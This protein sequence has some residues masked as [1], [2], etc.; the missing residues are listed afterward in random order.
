M[1][2]PAETVGRVAAHL[3]LDFTAARA[4]ESELRYYAKS[5]DPGEPFDPAGR[6]ARPALPEGDA[7]RVLEVVGD[8]PERL[9]ARRPSAGQ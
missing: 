3:G 7:A 5:T 8:L 9:A 4:S 1:G 6:H 2:R